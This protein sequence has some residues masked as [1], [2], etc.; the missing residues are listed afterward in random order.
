LA[1]GEGDEL[2]ESAP[3]EKPR[4]LS[5]WPTFNNPLSK[6]GAIRPPSKAPP[7]G[8]ARTRK[9]TLIIAA[10]ALGIA[11]VAGAWYGTR[12]LQER[13]PAGRVH[14]QLLAWQFAPATDVAAHDEAFAELDRMGTSAL[15]IVIDKLAD[16][17]PAKDGSSYSTR[18][19]QMIAHDYLMYVAA[20]L[21]TP[22][23]AAAT[24]VANALSSGVRVAD[25]QWLAARDAWRSWVSE[26]QSKGLLPQ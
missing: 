16:S 18:T 13:S 15:V 20:R 23:P 21:K 6:P 22:P 3:V 19:V 26:Q 17:S 24:E 11:V 14:R 2:T 7:P 10:I 12:A 8:P 9:S 5:L 25:G 4:R 1:L